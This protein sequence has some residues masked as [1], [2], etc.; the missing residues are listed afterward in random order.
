MVVVVLLSFGFVT[1]FSRHQVEENNVSAFSASLIIGLIFLFCFV[2]R[3]TSGTVTWAYNAE[4]MTEKGCSIATGFH[5]FVAFV[6]ALV[7]PV[8]E[9]EL[10]VYT[11]FFVF[12]GAQV[13]GIF[14]IYP[15]LKETKGL[16]FSEV[17]KAF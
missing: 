13:V 7:F 8:L 16:T 6:I 11:L 5:Y 12:G 1:Y 10:G 14:Y 17:K 15:R 9:A 3:L 4:I 2:F